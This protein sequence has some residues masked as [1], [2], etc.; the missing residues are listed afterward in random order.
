MIPKVIHYCWFGGGEI[1]EKDKKCIESWHKF[2]PDYE[3]KLWDESN[4]DVKKNQYMYEAHQ[5]K[6]WS[7]V[8]DVARLDIIYHYGGIYLDTDV[9]LVRSLDDLLENEAYMGREKST[10]IASGLGFGAVPHHDGIKRILDIYDNLVFIKEDGTFNVTPCPLMTTQFLL[11][12][13]AKLEDIEQSVLG[14]RIY[15]SE[16]LCP[17]NYGTGELQLTDRSYSIHRYS[18]SWVDPFF[19]KWKLREQKLAKKIGTRNAKRLIPI[20]NFPERVINKFKTLGPRKAMLF[21][22]KKFK[23]S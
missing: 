15:P 9:E 12:Y 14:I 19:K 17:L 18:M 10:Y 8:S 1:P 11:Q 16:V 2:C 5:S 13:G 23:G 22:K 20:L 7:F 4:Y 3:I 6:K 21:I